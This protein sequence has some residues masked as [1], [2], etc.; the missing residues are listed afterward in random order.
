MAC[1][2]SHRPSV[3]G[4]VALHSQHPLNNPPRALVEN[5]RA[6]TPPHWK[7]RYTW[8]EKRQTLGALLRV[9][10]AICDG[11]TTERRRACSKVLVDTFVN[12]ID[13]TSWQAALP[14][15]AWQSLLHLLHIVQCCYLAGR[16]LEEPYRLLLSD[17]GS[18]KSR[19]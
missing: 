19:K 11:E 16:M 7:S 5:C 12:V 14:N 18:S 10:S 3:A 2:E 15:W 6:M 1:A 13:P 17:S 9:Q 8:L 4:V